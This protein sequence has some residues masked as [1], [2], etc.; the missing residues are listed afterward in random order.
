MMLLPSHYLAQSQRDHFVRSLSKSRYF[1]FLMDGTTDSGKVEDE[2]IIVLH[3]KQDDVVKEIRTC[4]RYLSLVTPN[5]ADTDGLVDCL[6]EA[7]K[8]L[9]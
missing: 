3:C 1:S 6:K 8:R 4:A 2:L 7:L 5:K 9:N